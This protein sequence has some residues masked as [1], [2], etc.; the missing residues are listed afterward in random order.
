GAVDYFV[1]PATSEDKIQILNIARS[2]EPPHAA[3][4][5]EHWFNNYSKYFNVA[6]NVMRE[7][8]AFFILCEPQEVSIETHNIDPIVELWSNHLES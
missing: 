3:D 1:E 5:M 6:K 2:T 7:V 4:I 8:E